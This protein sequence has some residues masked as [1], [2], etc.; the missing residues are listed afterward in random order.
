MQSSTLS[1]LVYNVGTDV[2]TPVNLA[3]P[4]YTPIP[5]DCLHDPFTYELH[6]IDDPVATFPTFINQYPTTAIT[7]ATQDRALLGTYNFRLV[8]TDPLTG[9]QNN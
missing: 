3:I 5:T 1:P 8:A 2:L 6:Y 9:L 4:V 7:V